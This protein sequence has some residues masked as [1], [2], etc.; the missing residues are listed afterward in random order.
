MM[1]GK[2]K[3]ELFLFVVLIYPRS[4]ITTVSIKFNNYY[5]LG[6]ICILVLKGKIYDFG[7]D[8]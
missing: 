3:L 2:Y 8:I 6:P 5:F 1:L 7:I 4:K